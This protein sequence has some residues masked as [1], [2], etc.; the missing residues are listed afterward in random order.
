VLRDEAGSFDIEGMFLR[1]GGIAMA[2]GLAVICR[3][4][5]RVTG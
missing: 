5:D 3:T 2:A 4:A 1:L